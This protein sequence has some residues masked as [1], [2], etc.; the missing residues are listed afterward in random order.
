MQV[1]ESARAT[2]NALEEALE[3]ARGFH[4]WPAGELASVTHRRPL[5]DSRRARAEAGA[6]DAGAGG[7]GLTIL[8]SLARAA[9]GWSS[10]CTQRLLPVTVVRRS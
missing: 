4:R 5:T 6:S 3:H 2:I 9:R 10:G 1:S 8:C 7:R